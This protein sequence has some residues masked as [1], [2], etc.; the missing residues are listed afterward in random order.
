V[1]SGW[2]VLMLVPAGMMRRKAWWCRK[3]SWLMISWTAAVPAGMPS[4]A[5]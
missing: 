2:P 4:A 5:S 1:A 3:F